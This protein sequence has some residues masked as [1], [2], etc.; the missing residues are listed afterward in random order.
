MAT[1]K[2]INGNNMLQ[3]NNINDINGKLGGVTT[4]YNIITIMQTILV[5]VITIMVTKIQKN[6]RR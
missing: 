4:I 5:I 2:Y 3:T 1:A 6:Y